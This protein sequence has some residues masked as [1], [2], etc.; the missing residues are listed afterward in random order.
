MLE[1]LEG[2]RGARLWTNPSGVWDHTAPF[3]ELEFVP[4]VVAAG[5]ELLGA[6][7]WAGV[8]K[9]VGA[10]L[11]VAGL[12]SLFGSDEKSFN[13]GWEDGAKFDE[14]MAAIHE[15]WLRLND[16]I[17][18]ACPAFQTGPYITEYRNDRTRFSQFYAQT[19]R[20]SSRLPLNRTPTSA[21]IGSA[22]TFWFGLMGWIKI[23]EQA[24]PGKIAPGLIEAIDETKKAGGGEGKE[25]INWGYWIGAGMLT[26]LGVAYFLSRRA[27]VVVQT[28]RGMGAFP[29]LQ[30]TPAQVRAQY[31]ADRAARV[32]RVRR[33]R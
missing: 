33:S 2:R 1:T 28:G 14:R 20:V 3:G 25:P 22:K 12:F 27:P 15:L 4:V 11:S 26:A 31:L 7:S 29:S 21:E 32:R 8:A 5:A 23:A 19:G 13:E 18:Q 10:G 30:L 17:S 9:V 16:R 6:L 24:C